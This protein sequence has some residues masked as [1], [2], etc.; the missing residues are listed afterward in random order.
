MRI[1]STLL[2]L[3]IINSLS[4]QKAIDK[5]APDL[6]QQLRNESSTS[7]LV[8]MRDQADLSSINP[9]WTK[10]EKGRF[11]FNALQAVAE[12]T[13]KDIIQHL[14][15][16][17]VNF[18]SYYL[19]NMISIEGNL[20]NFIDLAGYDNVSR[21]I[22]ND[23]MKVSSPVEI[24]QSVDLRDVEPEWGIKQ[25]LADSVWSLGYEGQGVTIGGQDTGYE[26]DLSPLKSKYR[27]YNDGDVDH[28]YHWHDAIHEIDPMHGDSI[29]QESNNPCGLN[30]RVPCD[31]NNHGTHTM[32]TMVGSDS[33]NQIGVAPKAQWIGCRNMERGYGT[34]ST[35]VE[36]FEWFLAPTDLN[37][38]NPKPELAPHV[39]NNSWG[40]IPDEGCSPEIFPVIEIA[41]DALKAAGVVVVVS[42]GNDGS[43]CGSI[44]NPAGIYEGSFTVGASNRND[45]ITSF[46][47][48]GVVTVDSSFRMKP[49]VVA[50]GASVRS[51]IKNGNY[52]NF[53][54]TSMAG[55]HVAGLV[56][57]I[58]SANPELAGKVDIIED[59]IEQS[60]IPRYSRQDCSG[61]TGDQLPN[62][63]FGYGRVD[64][65]AAVIKA[66]DFTTS[67]KDNNN[68]RKIAIFP[69]PAM[70]YINIASE[71]NIKQVE[72]YD[73][74]GQ[75]MI[76]KTLDHNTARISLDQL[77]QGIYIISVYS[78]SHITTEKIIKL[79]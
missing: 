78:E 8:L 74:R 76:N 17:G 59:I 29:I 70:D 42:A 30:L 64:A 5:I 12:N 58:I 69:N 52:A 13:Q 19:V 73:I 44:A 57:L 16:Q 56:A 40:C 18:Q 71:E 46:S 79:R 66:L 62:P 68:E 45:T 51:I 41:V 72:I 60:A 36:C 11:V 25:I 63:T 33:L 37:N 39:I 27:G 26:W 61:F 54:G 15:N 2:C 4:A 35:Y 6:L 77:E 31:D 20:D 10:E 3:F 50:P 49:N 43:R 22:K 65:L 9:N 38:E 21:I 67:T 47:S 48:R 1:I 55:P 75:I 23:A 24:K 14:N 32:G 28:N 7:A 34:P 53:S